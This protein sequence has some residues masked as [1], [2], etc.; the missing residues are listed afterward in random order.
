MV[1]H[2]LLGP[3]WEAEAQPL[4]QKLAQAPQAAPGHVPALIGRS[5]G[6]KTVLGQDFVEEKMEVGGRERLYKQVE[7]SFSQPNGGMCQHMLNWA[8]DA[9][10]GRGGGLLELYC[11]NGNFCIALAPNFDSVVATELSKVGISAAKHNLEANG[12]DNI[13]VAAISAEE[14]SAAYLDKQPHKKLQKAGVDLANC[15]FGTVL[16]D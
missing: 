3:E 11:G 2:K 15:S 9:T 8:L 6:K 14:F 7:A 4:R 1:Y 10:R 13:N 5:R 12:V 16:V